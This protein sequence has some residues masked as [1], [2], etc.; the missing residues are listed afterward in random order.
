MAASGRTC[1]LVAV[2][3]AL[4]ATSFAGAANDGLSLDFYRTSCPQAESIVFSFLQDAIRKDIGLAAALLRLHFHDCF[5]QGCDAS[6][7]LDKLPGDA[8]SEKETAPNVSLRK[9]AFQ[10]IDALRDRLDQASR[11]E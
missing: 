1:L 2:A 9:T 6:I 4:V 5:V 10:A 7:L 11:D 3:A 8:K